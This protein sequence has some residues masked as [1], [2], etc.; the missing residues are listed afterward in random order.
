MYIKTLPCAS[1]HTPIHTRS[2][3]FSPCGRNP[4][5]HWKT[6]LHEEVEEPKAILK[7]Q[8]HNGNKVFLI[9]WKGRPLSEAT[10]ISKALLLKNT[11]FIDRV[12]FRI[13]TRI[14]NVFNLLGLSFFY[15]PKFVNNLKNNFL[16]LFL[17][18][19]S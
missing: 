16:G 9:K 18:M 19:K 5:Q 13:H 12:R 15:K 8:V 14:L 10:W 3:I 6:N 2:T 1:V 17:V 4:P 11:Y 7:Q